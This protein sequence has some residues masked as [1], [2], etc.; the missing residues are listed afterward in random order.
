MT[1][2]FATNLRTAALLTLGKSVTYRMTPCN[3]LR[4]EWIR[5]HADK[6]ARD[7]RCEDGP[8][9]STY[10]AVEIDRDINLPEIVAVTLRL[11]RDERGRH[12][13]A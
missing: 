6:L 9:Y 5:S 3:A 13:W 11:A 2:A 7:R 12:V 4:F 10:R 1:K 8:S